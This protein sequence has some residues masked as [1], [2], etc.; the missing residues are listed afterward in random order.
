MKIDAVA[1]QMGGQDLSGERLFGL[2]F[3]EEMQTDRQY[4]PPPTRFFSQTSPS[5]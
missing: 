1:R 2:P 5:E 4:G 3:G